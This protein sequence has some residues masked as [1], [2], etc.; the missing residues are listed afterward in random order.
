MTR[1]PKSGK[2]KQWTTRELAAVPA[3]WKGDTLSDGGG[4]SGGVRLA[5]D[6]RV[7]VRFKFAFR[8]DGRLCWYQCGT[9]PGVDL[10]EIRRNRDA[11]RLQ[12]AQGI[13][14]AQA[15]EAARS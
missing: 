11:A 14:P 12:G 13:N 5:A 15:K 4:L 9:W 6:G 10:A 1:Y 3:A 2:G 8:W 7:S